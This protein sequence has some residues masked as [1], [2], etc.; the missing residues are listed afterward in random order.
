[1]KKIENRKF[2]IIIL[3]LIIFICCI[4]I[5]IGDFFFTTQ[6]YKNPINAYNATATNDIIT[7]ASD[8]A[9]AVLDLISL[10]DN[11]CLFLGKIDENRFVVNEMRKKK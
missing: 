3:A 4:T 10:D 7:G 2:F 8:E 1:M 5:T 11:N 9:V 6:Y